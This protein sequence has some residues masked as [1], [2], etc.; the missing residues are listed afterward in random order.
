MIRAITGS[1]LLSC[2]IVG[3]AQSPALPPPTITKTPPSLPPANEVKSPLDQL[4]NSRNELKEE[5]ES[6]NKALETDDA[7]EVERKA[8]RKKLD[9]IL[10]RFDDKA[11]SPAPPTPPKTLPKETITPPT[12]TENKQPTKEPSVSA[13]TDA[14]LLAQNQY[15]AGEFDAALRSFKLMDLNIYA[16]EDKAFIQYMTACCL[17]RTNKLN[18]AAV[19][20]REIA[21]AK[22]D[23]FI[24]ECALWQISS[25]RWREDLD[26]QLTQ[27]RQRREAMNPK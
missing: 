21:D 15:K 3:F 10:K 5:R 9:E 4:K 2:G 14:L 25:I 13:T 27:M 6:T 23:E 16:R 18:E 7:A 11:K 17:R 22:D 26:K 1:V 24:T 20:F 19:L 12:P 8:L